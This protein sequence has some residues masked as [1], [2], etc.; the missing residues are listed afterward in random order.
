MEIIS[1]Y[2]YW[3]SNNLT[4]SRLPYRRS[5]FCSTSLRVNDQTEILPETF[6][7]LSNIQPVLVTMVSVRLLPHFGFIR[8]ILL[9]FII[10]IVAIG[11]LFI[12][13]R[14][15]PT[16]FR[17]NPSP[18]ICWWHGCESISFCLFSLMIRI[19]N[20]LGTDFRQQ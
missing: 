4:E 3:I 13:N 16:S 1:P 5:T 2:K 15:F 18:I 20:K 6:N 14:F 8:N 11:G 19:R 7:L 12:I 10:F 9:T 17:P